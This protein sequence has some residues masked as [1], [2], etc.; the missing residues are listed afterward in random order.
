M[1]VSAG[2]LPLDEQA[3]YFCQLLRGNGTLVTVIR[4][5]NRVFDGLPAPCRSATPSRGP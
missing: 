1:S 3:G 4:A 5:G 2:R